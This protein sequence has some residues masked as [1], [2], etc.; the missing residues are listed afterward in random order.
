MLAIAEDLLSR[1]SPKRDRSKN[2]RGADSNDY[3]IKRAQAIIDSGLAAFELDEEELGEMKKSGDEKSLIAAIVRAETSVR[4]SWVAE[5]LQMGSVANV[6]R[7][8][9]A[10]EHRLAGERKLKR[11]QKEILAN[12][13]S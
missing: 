13:S 11:I 6:T 7:A 3:G 4:A 10:I 2:Y 5:K 8:S 1:R 9:K 12:I